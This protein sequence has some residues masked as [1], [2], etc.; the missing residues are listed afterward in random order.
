VIAGH[1]NSSETF[2]HR[3]EGD[4]GNREGLDKIASVGL[5]ECLRHAKGSLTPTFRNP[6]GGAIAHQIDHL[7]VS[8]GMI[9]SLVRCETGPQ[10]RVFA[11]HLSDHL[12]IIADFER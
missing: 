2:D 1:F 5:V 3:R 6:N 9:R 4:R 10:E 11:H 7:F 8:S 12:P